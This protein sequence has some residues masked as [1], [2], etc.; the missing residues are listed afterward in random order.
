LHR[1]FTDE[2]AKTALFA[3]KV[4]GKQP[5]MRAHGNAVLAKGAASLRTRKGCIDVLVRELR[6]TPIEPATLSFAL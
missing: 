4:I 3:L 6:N 5:S 2:A 1:N